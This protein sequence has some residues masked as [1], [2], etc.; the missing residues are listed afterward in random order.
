M[1]PFFQEI[2]WVEFSRIPSINNLPLQEQVRKYNIYMLDLHQAREQ[3]FIQHH[4]GK[5]SRKEIQIIGVL[6]QEDLF[7]ILQEDGSKI[8]ITTE[9]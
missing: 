9:I 4:E 8:Y 2:S 1:N 3:W 5:S 7:Y 6:L